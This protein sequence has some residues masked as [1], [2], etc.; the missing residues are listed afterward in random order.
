MPENKDSG[1]EATDHA[2]GGQSLSAPKEFF[3]GHYEP[4]NP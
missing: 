3:R 4:I 1:S 2:T